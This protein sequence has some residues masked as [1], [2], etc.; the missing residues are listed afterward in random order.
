LQPAV[1]R[2]FR[3]NLLRWF[4]RSRRD[5]PWRKD[6]TP[7]RVWISELML[8]QTRVDQVVPYYHRFLKRFP[9]VQVLARSPRQDVLKLWEGLG[10]YSRAIRA[11]ET[12]RHVA[13][14]LEGQFPATL[15]GLLALP[16]VGPYTAAAV[17]SLAFGLDAAVV[18]GNVARVL[19]RV[20]AYGEDIGSPAGK[21]LVQARAESLLPRGRAGVF[22]EAMMELGATVCLPRG[23]RCTACPLRRVCRARADGDPERYPV[24]KKKPRV[25]HK[26]VGAGIVMDRRGRF[27]IAQRKEGSMLG[28]LWEFPGGTQE[29]GETIEQ[30]IARELK[31]ELGIAVG[32]GAHFITVRHAFS[33]FTMDLHAHVCR[34]RSG[35]PRAIHCADWKWV[36]QDKLRRF[37]FGRAD[38]RIIDAI[39]SGPLSV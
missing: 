35:R 31:E 26:H 3:Q 13:G 4:S 8:Q 9:T 37:P 39:E 24:K 29:K 15:D 38:R 7:Y 12:A 5:L 34:L 33:H 23:P 30:C 16:G 32:V 21:R 11:H 10:Y 22:N 25:P 36:G 18:D 1:A 28:G 14:P 17:G 19:A 2:A 27:L 6:R 20:H